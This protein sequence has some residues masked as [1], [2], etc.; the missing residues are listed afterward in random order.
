MLECWSI[1]MVGW[2]KVGVLVPLIFFQTPVCAELVNV[3]HYDWGSHKVGKYYEHLNVVEDGTAPKGKSLKAN[4]NGG[5]WMPGIAHTRKT[6][7]LAGPVKVTALVR[8]K[9]LTGVA[10]QVRFVAALRNETTQ[11]TYEVKT[12]IQGVR[13]NKDA[14]V[15]ISVHEQ[16]P[17][18]PAE[19]NF[20]VRFRWLGKD[21]ANAPTVWLASVD[22]EA[23]G[24]KMPFIGDVEPDKNAYRPGEKIRCEVAVLNPTA[25]AIE[26]SIRAT[27]H[28]GLTG[29]QIVGK[30]NFRL[31]GGESRS[32]ELQWN[33]KSPDAGR[34]LQ[35][36]LLDKKGNEVDTFQD[37]YGIAKD[38]SFLAT[39]PAYTADEG[40]GHTH[41]Y[42]YV[43]PA[44]MS[45]V[46]RALEDIKKSRQ[47][48]FEFFSWS[49]NELG[50]FIPPEDEDPFLGNEGVW[51]QSFKKLKYQFG[52]VKGLGIPPITYVN[53]HV[54]GPAGYDLFLKHPEWF[55]YTE[56]GELVGNSYDMEWRDRYLRRDSFTFTQK[57]H[58]FFYGTLN[59]T[60]P[61]TRQHIANQFIRL[62]DELGFEGVR[63]DVW[64]MEIKPGMHDILGHEIVSNWEEADALSAESLAAVKKL[65][66]RKVKDFTWG[67]NYASPEEN[68]KTPK[69][70]E[71]KC[72]NGGW[73]L[74]EVVISYASKSSPNHYWHAYRDR[75]VQWGNRV[76]E[77]DGIY[78]PYALHRGGGKYPV[79]RL[80]E[81]IFRLLGSGRASDIYS[82][83]G[84]RVGR[85]GLM[86]FRFSNVFLGRRL[87]TLPPNQRLIHVNGPD[88]L[89][90]KKLVFSNVSHKGRQ[91]VI[92]HL[93]NSPVAAELEEGPDSRVRPPLIDVIVTCGR[94]K[95]KLPSRVW[96]VAAEPLTS[97]GEPTV[98]RV[99]LEQDM[100]EERS[101]VAVPLVLYWK[102]VVFEF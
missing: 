4:H 24:D 3:Y 6:I 81:G 70:F 67:Y 78:N 45:Q 75:M 50:Q 15:P 42:L 72:R 99:E 29:N 40:H 101:E 74:D 33:A 71:E 17:V 100:K 52:R 39:L 43:G 69:L 68:E 53:G 26:G 98:Q 63:W 62:A 21:P 57:K 102:T 14:F 12:L 9:G 48:R 36:A 32:I 88:T 27:E 2:W 86:A 22:V 30:E 23:A 64:S 11:R 7:R 51:W 58:P 82:C 79:D 95:G 18:E 19:Y 87:R 31:G 47:Q 44:S 55:L 90:W 66:A 38:P 83:D 54:W 77:L 94:L 46:N 1:G 10:E 92:L 65:V 13:V 35:V 37:Y 60:L 41:G 5:A 76:R 28:L 59:P 80:Y 49:Y 84:S 93:V 73:L 61:D 20:Y 25:E 34:E 96:L 91:Q 8:G 56:A 85:L 89:W 16:L 97:D